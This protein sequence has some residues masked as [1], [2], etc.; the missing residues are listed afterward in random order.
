[1]VR[2]KGEW[3]WDMGQFYNNQE[4]GSNVGGE[5]KRQGKRDTRQVAVGKGQGEMD[6]K[7]TE[8]KFFV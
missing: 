6:F 1:M 4:R 7:G 5:K 3:M 8:N 2:H